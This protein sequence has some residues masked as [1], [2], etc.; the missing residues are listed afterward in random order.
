M[1]SKSCKLSRCLIIFSVKELVN[2][3][4]CIC[5][6]LTLPIFSDSEL[7][8]TAKLIYYCILTS[9]NRRKMFTSH[10]LSILLFPS[11]SFFV[12]F[13]SFS[14]CTVITAQQ[15]YSL[16]PGFCNLNHPD[17]PLN[18]HGVLLNYSQTNRASNW[19]QDTALSQGHCFYGYQD[20]INDWRDESLI[21]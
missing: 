6:C 14:C 18:F 1:K 10:I 17:K 8:G 11:H 4:N 21:S 20:I 2:A 15:K 19:V 3:N 16:R 12:L 7:S 5:N 13:L 9:V